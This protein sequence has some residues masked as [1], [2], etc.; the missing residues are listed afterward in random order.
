MFR[1]E[2]DRVVAFHPYR[3]HQPWDH[4]GT[5]LLQVDGVNGFNFESP[6]NR[7]MR[8]AIADLERE[9]IR[10]AREDG[11]TRVEADNH[12]GFTVVV[13]RS[14]PE[15]PDLR[16][17]VYYQLRFS[18]GSLYVWLMPGAPNTAMPGPPD[19]VPT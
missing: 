9:V 17:Q 4:G 16:T 13:D 11:L 14:V 2:F 1:F 19:G 15:E 7:A 5:R 6:A 3:T 12:Y 10:R 8:T 18:D